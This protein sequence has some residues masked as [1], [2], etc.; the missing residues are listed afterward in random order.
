MNF[1]AA[2]WLAVALFVLVSVPPVLAA[3]PAITYTVTMPQP[4]KHVFHVAMEI[5]NPTSVTLEVR[6]PTWMQ[7]IYELQKYAEQVGQ[8][9]AH[10]PSGEPVGL[11]ALNDHA[12]Q[13]TPAG[14]SPVVIE[15]DLD[16]GGRH[17]LF[18]K[19]YLEKSAALI[20]GGSFFLYSP[21]HRR[22]SVSVTIDLPENWQAATALVGSTG[23][24]GPG[25]TTFVAQDYDELT[26]SPIMLGKF[27]RTDFEVAGIPFSVVT[28]ERLNSRHNGLV[29]SA[30]KIAAHT[31][32]F[33]GGAPFDRYLFLYFDTDDPSGA[34]HKTWMV[35]YEHLKSTLITVDP[36]LGQASADTSN[37]LYRSVSAHELFHAWN[38]KAIRPVALHYPDL[39]QPPAVRS[40]WLL[41]GFTEYYA[42]KFMAQIFGDGKYADFYARM[43]RYLRSAAAPVSL[44]QVSLSAATESLDEFS[45]LYYRGSSAALLLDLRLRQTTRNERGLDDFMRALWA[46]YGAKRTPYAEDALPGII[47]EIAAADVGDFHLHYLAGIYPLPVESYLRFG[48]WGVRGPTGKSV[49][50]GLALNNQ[51]GEITDIVPDGNAD[52]AG[53]KLKD[54]VIAINGTP[55]GRGDDWNRLTEKRGEGKEFLFAIERAGERQQVKLRLEAKVPLEPVMFELPD[56]TAEQL[57]TRRAVLA[58]TRA[59]RAAAGS[60][61]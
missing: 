60:S 16:V 19:S 61:R 26:D 5:R 33:F 21:A 54:K 42:Q 57:A 37:F 46:H 6:M 3:E 51:T 48:G 29:E 50:L 49:L 34:G 55:L 27:Q 35:G 25:T 8:I 11:T 47:N 18:G 13:V 4:S 12:W 36:H 7:A 9:K 38:V 58:P 59:A 39:D 14:S 20:H 40:L 23:G 31:I 28:D 44:E 22:A 17:K 24:R 53:L 43:N 41:E 32:E 1:K 2:R 56:A 30:R 15:Y 10:T 52:K 45:L